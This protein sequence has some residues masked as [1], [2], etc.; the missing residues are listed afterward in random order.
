M[1]V[2]LLWDIDGTLL[3]TAGAGV[4]ALHRA[5]RAVC[6]AD[7]DLGGLRTDGLTDFEVAAAVIE[8]ATGAPPDRGVAA[9]FLDRYGAELPSV[10]GHRAGTVL[11]GVVAILEDLAGRPDVCSLL[12][13]GNTSQGA[14]AKLAHYG[15][16]RWLAGGAFCTGP[17]D[18]AAIARA[19][20]ALAGREIGEQPALDRVFVIGD[21][22]RDVACGTAIGARTIAVASGRYGVEELAACAPWTVLPRLPGPAAFRRLV[23]LD[24]TVDPSPQMLIR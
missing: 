4:E 10:L 21:T 3:S 24:A 12:L 5:A 13:T 8:R 19:A 17:G 18:R 6:R 16:D 7:A 14:K 2:T 11:P 1:T 20:L 23:G 22:P 9:A 15:L